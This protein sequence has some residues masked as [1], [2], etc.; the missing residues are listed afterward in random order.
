MDKLEQI[1]KITEELFAH[2]K[3]QVKVDIKEGD[4]GRINIQLETEEPGILIGYHGEALSA[5]QRMISMMAFK[6][7]GEWT[8]ISVNVA[9]YLE[10]RQENL[11][12]MATMVAQKAKFSN[13]AQTLPPMSAA[14]RRIIHLVLGNDSSI[15]TISEGLGRE[16]HIV[17]KPK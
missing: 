5:I 13:Q 8:G 11:K 2:L 17:I 15:E 16:R 10:K 4:G 7:L 12:R 6:K 1:K 3:V 14:E 9:D